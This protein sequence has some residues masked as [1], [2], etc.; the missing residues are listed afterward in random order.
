MEGDKPMPSQQMEGVFEVMP[1]EDAKWLRDSTAQLLSASV[2]LLKTFRGLMDCG[3][4]TITTKT[5]DASKFLVEALTRLE[6]A[7]KVAADH[8]RRR[9]A[10]EA[11]AVI[12]TAA[13]PT[14]LEVKSG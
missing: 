3:D 2:D 9:R 6:D 12:G 4:V 1:A 11:T 7:V 14:G 13:A 5:E 10:Q 8:E